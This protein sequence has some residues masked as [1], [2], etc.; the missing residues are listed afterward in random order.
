MK[1]IKFLAFSALL[2]STFTFQSC[3]DDDDE[4][5]KPEEVVKFK[6]VFILN[7]AFQGTNQSTIDCYYPNGENSVQ[8]KVFAATNGEGLGDNGQDIICYGKRVYLSVWG[9]NY[10]AKLDQNGKVLEKYSFKTDEGQPRYLVA[11]DGFV[12][13]STYGGK[14]A[15]FDTTTI[16]A[17]LDFVEVGAHPEEICVK[18]NYLYA[19]IAGDY[20]VKYENKIAVVDLSDFSFKEHIEILDDP[21]NVL[22]LKDKL[23]VVHYTDPQ[24]GVTE[25]LEVNPSAKQY[26]VY[27]DG[28]KIA[29]DGDN[30]FVISVATDWS[31]YPE[32]TTVTT[33]RK[34][35][36]SNSF[37]DLSST[38]ELS[39]SIVYMFEID[40]ENKDFYIGTTDYATKSVVYRFNKSG[41]FVEKF[42]TSS[43]NPNSAAFVY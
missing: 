13:V 41:K 29:T 33:Y 6:H 3:K 16:A 36:A 19:A 40:P 43:L 42:E 4:E 14:V 9:S 24:N 17:P 37:L 10:I 15:K 12:Y 26:S 11:K 30:L 5:T 32:V 1:K 18:D 27:S 38:P 8:Q 25:V 35:K 34:N 31:N 28:A 39:S 7:E 20:N 2:L 23:Y 21:T 22:A